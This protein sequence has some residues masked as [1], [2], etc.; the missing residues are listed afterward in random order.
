MASDRRIRANRLNAQKTTGPKTEAGKRIVSQNALKHGLRS[1]KYLVIGEDQSEFNRLAREFKKVL[2]P[3][4][5]VESEHCN[6]IIITAW[7][8]KRCPSVIAGLYNLEIIEQ[9]KQA[10]DNIAVD[11]FSKKELQ[12]IVVDIDKIPE[13]QAI[14]L[15]R[16]CSSEKAIS[17]LS[18]TEQK[19]HWTY[20]KLL[21]TYIDNRKLYQTLKI[22]ED[23]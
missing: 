6:Q 21:R 11:N 20:H 19:L 12:K 17:T 22:K 1:K 4:N 16:D 2:L 5:A 8:L 23:V 3:Q 15:K 14:A 9:I 7:Q 10:S 18:L 13:I